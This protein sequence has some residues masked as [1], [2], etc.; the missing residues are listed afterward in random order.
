MATRLGSATE[1]FSATSGPRNKESLAPIICWGLC[2][3]CRLKRQP[4]QEYL[5][6]DS[7]NQPHPAMMSVF[8]E[9]VARYL[10]AAEDDA[11]IM[12]WAGM[13]KTKMSKTAGR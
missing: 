6:K 2:D 11:F 1:R 12:V 8:D 10:Y 3:V 5:Q 13:K 4:H 9:A 7:G